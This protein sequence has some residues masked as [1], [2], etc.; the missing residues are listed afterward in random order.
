M[1]MER[2]NGASDPEEVEEGLE[3]TTDKLCHRAAAG[4]SRMYYA[5]WGASYIRMESCNANINKV[6][7]AAKENSLLL[8]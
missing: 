7:R 2:Q 6:S 1:I 8:Y 3:V 5:S 4:E